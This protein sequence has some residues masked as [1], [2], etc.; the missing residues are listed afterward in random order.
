M[1]SPARDIAQLIEDA[2]S[3]PIATFGTDMFVGVMPDVPDVA[4]CCYD[5]GGGAP[6]D[7]FGDVT[8]MRPT[9]QVIIRARTYND[10]Y[11]KANQIVTALHGAYEQIVGTNRYLGVWLQSDIIS[12][13]FDVKNRTQLS[14]NFRMQRTPSQA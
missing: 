3:A 2:L 13:G 14:V 8:L 5:T 6:L 11:T 9:V 7:T 10:A 12:L 1:S 4:V